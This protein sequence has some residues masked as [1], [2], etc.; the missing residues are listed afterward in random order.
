M[1]AAMAQLAYVPQVCLPCRISAHFDARV[2]TL[3]H[4]VQRQQTPAAYEGA[5]GL[6]KDHGRDCTWPGANRGS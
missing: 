2:L 6:R 1:T 3:A 4:E 5:T